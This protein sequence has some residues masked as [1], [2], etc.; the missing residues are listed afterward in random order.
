[1]VSLTLAPKVEKT[2]MYVE[3]ILKLSIK[4]IMH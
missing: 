3:E 1:M 4:T 2:Y